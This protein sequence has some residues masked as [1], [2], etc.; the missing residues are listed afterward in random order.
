MSEKLRQAKDKIA[1]SWSVSIRKLSQRVQMSWMSTKRALKRSRLKPFCIMLCQ[2]LKPADCTKGEK[3]CNGFSNFVRLAIYFSY[4]ACILRMFL[5][6]TPQNMKHSLYTFRILCQFR[7]LLMPWENKPQSPL[8]FHAN[9][10]PGTKWE[11][12][13]TRCETRKK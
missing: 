8:T 12:Q 13:K 6:N 9:A 7:V 10:N 4:F 1:K 2:E 11:K 3:F 5:R